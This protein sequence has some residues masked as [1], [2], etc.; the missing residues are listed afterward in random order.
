MRQERKLALLRFPDLST[1]GK[2]PSPIAARSEA[3]TRRP[4][5]ARNTAWA[6]HMLAS[7]GQPWI[8]TT[9]RPEP[10]SLTKSS[11][12]S[13]FLMKALVVSAWLRVHEPNQRWYV[14]G[15]APEATLARSAIAR[16][17]AAA[18]S[19]LCPSSTRRLGPQSPSLAA[20]S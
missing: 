2:G 18:G 12:P 9:E 1:I 13:C 4:C 19:L 11:V 20:T 17:G 8:S 3:T 7:S 15:E 16:H 6:A 10:Q 14:D 5:S